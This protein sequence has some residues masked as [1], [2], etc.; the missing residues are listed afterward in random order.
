MR[1][2]APVVLRICLPLLAA[3]LLAPVAL[4]AEDA[5][6]TPTPI[7]ALKLNDG[8]VL[9]NVQVKKDQDDSI[10]VRA[11][12]GLVKIAKS[13]LPQE[14][15]DAYP[16]KPSAAAKTD[17]VMQVFNPGSPQAGGGQAPYVRPMPRPTPTPRP[18]RDPV[19]KGCTI[20]SFQAKAFQTSLGCAEVVIRND[21]DNVAVISPGEIICV[22]TNGLRRP[23]RIIVTDGVPPIIK[24]QEF[25]PAHG[26]VD[27]IVT[28]TNDAL[29]I[30][31]VQWAR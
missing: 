22:T 26:D 5:N 2:P 31:Y 30:S 19:Y 11:D 7:A 27:D 16:A 21:T 10:V 25:I 24:R 6:P 18:T 28:F 23:G 17:M 20:V 9:H 15:A 13:N 29:D 8:R 12:E 1:L 4:R 14:V 3:G